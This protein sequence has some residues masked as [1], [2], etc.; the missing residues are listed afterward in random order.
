M[1]W[2]G[3]IWLRIQISGGLLWIR[4]WTSGFHKMLRSSSCLKLSTWRTERLIVELGETESL[5]TAVS[6][7]SI[8]PIPQEIYVVTCRLL[9][10]QRLCKQHIVGNAYKNTRRAIRRQQSDNIRCYATLCKQKNKERG[11]S[12]VTRIAGQRMCFI[13]VRLEVIYVVQS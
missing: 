8:L 2:I 9:S 6:N 13:W 11:V 4:Y 12:Y 7:C 10:S 5:D 3:W 1:M